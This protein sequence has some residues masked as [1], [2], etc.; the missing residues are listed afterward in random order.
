MFQ[1]ESSCRRRNEGGAD[2]REPVI[3]HGF[4]PMA[5]GH[6][7]VFFPPPNLL[8]FFVESD[9]FLVLVL[10]CLCLGDPNLILNVTGST[11]TAG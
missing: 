5:H 8:V 10:L 6:V 11:A 1:A 4:F 3:L 9:H 2:L 7:E